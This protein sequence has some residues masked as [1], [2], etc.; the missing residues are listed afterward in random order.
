MTFVRSGN[1]AYIKLHCVG[2]LKVGLKID[3]SRVLIVAVRFHINL[4]II[5]ETNSRVLGVR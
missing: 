2:K 3:A 4:A 1:L 5:L